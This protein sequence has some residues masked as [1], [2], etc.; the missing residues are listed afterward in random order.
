MVRGPFPD[1]VQLPDLFYDLVVKLHHVLGPD[2]FCAVLLQ[3]EQ[4]IA[5][6]RELIQDLPLPLI[7]GKWN[8]W[9]FHGGIE[10]VG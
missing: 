7:L 10:S 5:D 3:K 8:C 1:L 4:L 2:V 9:C 6:E